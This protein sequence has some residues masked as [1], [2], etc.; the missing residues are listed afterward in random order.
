MAVA[1]MFLINVSQFIWSIV[2]QSQVA[3]FAF[4]FVV[5]ISSYV[6]VCKNRV[7]DLFKGL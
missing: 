4:I 5:M 2:L 7:T 3:R 6:K 1:A